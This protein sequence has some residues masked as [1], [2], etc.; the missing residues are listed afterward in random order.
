MEFSFEKFILQNNLNQQI[1]ETQTPVLKKE[2]TSARKENTIERKEFMRQVGIG[3]GAILLTNCLTAC[4][5]TE[6]PDPMPGT[7]GDKLDFTLNLNLSGNTKLNTAGGFVVSQNVI[8][9]KTL[10]NNFL[11]VASGCTHQGTTISYRANSNDFKCPNHGS[12]FTAVGA[13]QLGPATAALAKYKTAFD[14]TANTLRI[15]E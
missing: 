8:I 2:N 10:D 4:G 3:F 9:A 6:I 14:K 15:F 13:V 11:A 12:E 1:M 5:D 7:G